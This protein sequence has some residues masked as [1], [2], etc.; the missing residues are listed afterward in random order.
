ME[1]KSIAFF[2]LAFCQVAPTIRQYMYPFIRLGGERH[3]KIQVYFPETQNSDPRLGSNW[4]PSSRLFPSSRWPSS[5]IMEHG[6]IWLLFTEL[7]CRVKAQDTGVQSFGIR[8]D[9][10]ALKLHT[11][12]LCFFY[13]V[14]YKIVDF[15]FLQDGP[16]QCLQARDMSFL[17]SCFPGERIENKQVLVNKSMPVVTASGIQPG[18]AAMFSLVRYSVL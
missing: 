12:R 11:S 8:V 18:R 4:S 16:S 17:C 10:K 1:C 13:K 2:F 3:C 9:Q 6:R 14:V 5:Y 15:E 7:C